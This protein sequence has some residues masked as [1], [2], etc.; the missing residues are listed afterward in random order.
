MTV[1]AAIVELLASR[2]GT[3]S[4][5]WTISIGGHPEPLIL[6]PGLE[7]MPRTLQQAKTAGPEPLRKRNLVAP[8]EFL[9][10]R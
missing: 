4:P 3:A 2:T 7:Q 10:V 5:T 6:D 1:A 8:A 9:E